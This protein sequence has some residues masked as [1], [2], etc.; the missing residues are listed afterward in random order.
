MLINIEQLH[1]K[2]NGVTRNRVENQFIDDISF[3]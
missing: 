3:N 2:K 1:V